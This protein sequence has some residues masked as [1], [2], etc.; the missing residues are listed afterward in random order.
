MDPGNGVRTVRPFAE[1]S[2]LPDLFQHSVPY[3][4][5]EFGFSKILI[6][7]TS[8]SVVTVSIICQG[9]GVAHTLCLC[10]SFGLDA[11]FHKEVL[12][13]QILLNH[14]LSAATLSSS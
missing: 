5:F 10:V 12:L 6:K 9:I 8:P 3:C 2:R 7:L 1:L 13:P 11:S 14:A 4:R